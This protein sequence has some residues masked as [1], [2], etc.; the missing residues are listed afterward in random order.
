MQSSYQHHA[1]EIRKLYH[2]AQ[3]YGNKINFQWIPGHCRIP[4]CEA[5]DNAAKCTVSNSLKAITY[6]QAEINALVRHI[7]KTLSKEYWSYQS[8]HHARLYAL[9]PQLTFRSP[10]ALPRRKEA[11]LYRLRLGVEYTT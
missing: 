10:S 8:Y 4:G 3:Q 6:S 7:G 1:Y 11:T 5:P 9:D 2:E